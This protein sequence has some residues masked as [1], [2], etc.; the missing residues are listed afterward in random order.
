[1]LAWPQNRKANWSTWARREFG[2]RVHAGVSHGHRQCV[3]EETTRHYKSGGSSAR[4]RAD[5]DA[6][7]SAVQG[8]GGGVVVGET[9]RRSRHRRLWGVRVGKTVL[10]GL[11]EARREL[12]SRS[13]SALVRM[14]VGDR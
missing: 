7:A 3:L 10:G 13:R 9:A 2:A 8:C 5:V 12:T 11:V 14:T 1:M 6:H 4:A